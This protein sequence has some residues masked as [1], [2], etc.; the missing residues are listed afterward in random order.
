M[1]NRIELKRN[2]KAAFQ[3]NY[4]RCVIVALIAL[5]ILGTSTLTFSS[6]APS[7]EREV[8]F[9]TQLPQWFKQVIQNGHFS[10]SLR[11]GVRLTLLNVFVFSVLEIGCDSFFLRNAQADNTTVDE[12]LCG[13]RKGYGKN[14]LT[15]FLVKLYIGLWSLLFVIP[16]IVKAYSYTLVPYILADSPELSRRDAMQLSA[17]LMNGSKMDAFI[18]DL[19]FIGWEILS[20]LTAGIA[21]V[22]FVNPYTC[23]TK[24]ELYLALR[25]GKRFS[26]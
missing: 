18:L 26:A 4:G 24:A 25:Y 5:L 11:G 23:A 9:L 2:G 16:G 20:V 7:V 3:R 8:S 22:L 1:W 14:V 10:I 17:Q 13:F 12:V 6:D 15:M 19:S 21:G